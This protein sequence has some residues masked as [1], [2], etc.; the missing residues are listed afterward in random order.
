MSASVEQ[1]KT[2]FEVNDMTPAEIAEDQ[3]LDLATVKAAL[4]HCST[5]YRKACGLES[6][7][8]DGLNF[9]DDELRRVNEVI[10]QTALCAETSDGEIDW[11]TRLAAATYIRDDKKGRKEAVRFQGNHPTF[12]ILSFNEDLQ[13]VRSV[14]RGMKERL[15]EA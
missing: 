9:T 1:I 4:M 14:V 11:K 15:I 6:P 5:K 13:K 3:D 12:N 8:E 2:A 10:L 7:A